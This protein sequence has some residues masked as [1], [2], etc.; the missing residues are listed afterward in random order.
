MTNPKDMVIAKEARTVGL[1]LFVT[2]VLWMG[3][4]VV[5]R[6][7]GWPVRYALL[8]D[9]AALAGFIW[10]LVATYRIWRKRQG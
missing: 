3:L 9:L 1:A 4:Q 10:C 2:I 5:G 7:M 8:I 6:D